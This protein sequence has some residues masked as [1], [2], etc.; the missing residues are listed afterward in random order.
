MLNQQK[1][2]VTAAECCSRTGDSCDLWTWRLGSRFSNGCGAEWSGNDHALSPDGQHLLLIRDGMASVH[3]VPTDKRAGRSIDHG[4]PV[5]SAAYSPDGTRALTIG[6][7]GGIQVWDARSWKPLARMNDPDSAGRSK[8]QFSQDNRFVACW[9]SWIG[10]L[11]DLACWDVES[12]RM[13]RAFDNRGR[14][15]EGM[16]WRP[17]SEQLLTTSQRGEVAFWDVYSPAN[18][19]TIMRVGRRVTTAAY[20]PDAR[21]LLTAAEDGEIRIWDLGNGN[22]SFALKPPL[23]DA[24]Y[25]SIQPTHAMFGGGNVRMNGEMKVSVKRVNGSGLIPWTDQERIASLLPPGTQFQYAAVSPDQNRVLT[26]HGPPG[27]AEMKELQL[28]DV[29][30]KQK[31]AHPLL[32]RSAINCAAFSSDSRLVVAGCGDGTVCLI[33]ARTGK[34]VGSPLNHGGEVLYA[35]FSSDGEL[36]ATCGSDGT[37]RLWRTRT[38]QPIGERLVHEGVVVLAAFSPDGQIVATSSLDGVICLW[39]DRGVSLGMLKCES[40]HASGLQFHPSGLL[41]YFTRPGVR[42]LQIPGS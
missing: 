40:G 22:V 16:D 34:P 23:K 30:T 3:N 35:V 18:P 19:A 25:T 4:S 5:Q 28:W 11:R 39:D 36:L 21:M 33:D 37:A 7:D 41:L 10:G 17:D 15:L 20:G 42:H 8:G 13:I 2:A 26:G 29:K 27:T 32:T 38:G 14:D 31:L 9:G 24:F 12:G 6:K 1:S